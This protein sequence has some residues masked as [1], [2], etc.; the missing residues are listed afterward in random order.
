VG[1]AL[2]DSGRAYSTREWYRVPS[3]FVSLIYD[4]LFTKY[5]NSVNFLL[6]DKFMKAV[7]N[8]Y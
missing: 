6:I 3:R 2:W 4:N 1:R 8:Y 7:S 5:L